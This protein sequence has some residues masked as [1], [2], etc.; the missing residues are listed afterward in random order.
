MPDYNIYVNGEF[1]VQGEYDSIAEAARA[2]TT[3]RPKGSDITIKLADTL[4][5]ELARR[6]NLS[7]QDV[8]N[9]LDRGNELAYSHEMN[10]GQLH[11]YK[12][13]SYNPG[14]ITTYVDTD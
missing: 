8:Q 12:D 11:E 4:I 6:T 14:C 2:A 9:V 13:W 7:V 10:L 3:S 5:Q 1:V